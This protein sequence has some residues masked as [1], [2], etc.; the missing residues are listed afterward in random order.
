MSALENARAAAQKAAEE[1]AA[2][3]AQEAEKAAQKAAERAE[4]QQEKDTAFLAQWEKLDADL[5]AVGSKSAAEIIYEGGDVIQAVALFHIQRAKRN[6][7]RAH[8]RAAYFRL[9]GEH[10]EDRSAMELTQR[11]MMIAD[12]LEEA[13]TRAAGMHAADLVGALEAEWMVPDGE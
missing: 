13:I 9:H 12:R 7:V 8:A 3:E 1:L 11:D 10:P 2:L 5:Q 6:A 4:R